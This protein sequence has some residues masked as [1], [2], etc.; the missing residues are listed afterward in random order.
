MTK[1]KK[2]LVLRIATKIVPLSV[3]GITY[4]NGSAHEG[5]KKSLRALEFRLGELTKPR[6]RLAA[7]NLARTIQVGGP[8]DVSGAAP[9]HADEL[10]TTLGGVASD[11]PVRLVVGTKRVMEAF[12]TKR[13]Q[14]FDECVLA[15]NRTD[16]VGLIPKPEKR[17]A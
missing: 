1:R 9:V 17:P 5:M 16:L 8:W 12:G 3:E 6:K 15:L 13:R 14:E 7:A 11:L 10:F 4:V 2:Q